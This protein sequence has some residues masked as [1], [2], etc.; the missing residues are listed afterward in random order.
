MN[1]NRDQIGNTLLAGLDAALA[2][3]KRA[4]FVMLPPE[5]QQDWCDKINASV[6]LLCDEAPA[7][8]V[9]ADVIGTFQVVADT[10]PGVAPPKVRLVLGPLARPAEPLPSGA[11]FAY[12]HQ[13]G[14]VVVNLHETDPFVIP[15]ANAQGMAAP[16]KVLAIVRTDPEG[17]Q[18]PELV[19]ADVPVAPM[20]KETFASIDPVSP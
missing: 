15:L 4:C 19:V 17:N 14:V 12:P 13:G 10:E 16:G 7:A 8:P 6:G 2:A 5:A 20:S 1:L 3:D 9:P 11:G 18:H